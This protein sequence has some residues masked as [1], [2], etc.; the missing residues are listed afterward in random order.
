MRQFLFILVVLLCIAAAAFG[1]S[2]AGAGAIEGVVQDEAQAVIPQ[3]NV[4][5]RNAQTGQVRQLQT[6]GTGRY[7][8]AGLQPG[9]YEIEVQSAGF[10]RVIHKGITVLVGQKAM[11]DVMLKVAATQETVTVTGELP[12]V[13]TD[14]TEVSSYVTEREVQNL[15]VNG[16]RWDNFV[17]LTPAV[18][19]DGNYGMVS[20]RGISGLYNNNMIDGADNNQ[21][22]FSEARGRTRIGYSISQSTIKEFQVGQSNYSAEFGRAAGGLVNA[23]TRSGTNAAHGE[24]FYYIRD[25]AMNAQNPTIAASGQQK[26]DDRRQQFGGFLGGA[27]KKDKLFYLL[28]YD[29]QKRNFPAAILP[30]STSFYN[31][32]SSKVAPGFDNLA[33]LYKGLETLQPRSGNQNLGLAKLDWQMSSANLLSTTLNVLRWDSLNGIQTQPKHGY[34]ATA[35]G[36]DNVAHEFV[37]T[38]LSS[39]LTPTTLNEFRFQYGRDFESQNPNAPGPY[40][41]P[42]NGINTGMPAYLPRAAYPNEKTL[43]FVNNLSLVRGSHQLKIGAEMRYVRDSYIN[44]Y[45]GG[46]V[47]NYSS[48]NDLALDCPNATGFPLTGCTPT[49]TGT[50]TQFTGV[51]GKHYSSFYQAFDALNQ[52]GA[53][54]FNTVDYALYL[55]DNLKLGRKLTVNLGL[56]YE[57]QAMPEVASPNPDLPLSAKFN[58]DRN[59]FGPRVG[60]AWTPVNKF[61]VRAGY[62]LYY[63][64]TQN[65][66][67]SQA[68]MSNGARTQT[69][70][71]ASNYAGSPS[72]P[73]TFSAIPTGTASK[74]DASLL[75]ADYVNP[76]IH[77]FEFSLEREVGRGIAVQATYMASRGLRLPYFRDTNLFPTSSTITYTVDCSAAGSSPACAD[78]PSSFTVP[79]YT[80]GAN[81]PNANY[82]R[83]T[84][85]ESIV[86]SWY[87]GLVLEARKRQGRSLSFN[88]SLTYAKAIDTGQSGSSAT[89]FSGIYPLDPYNLSS[90]KAVSVLDQRKRFVSS[91]VWSPLFFENSDPAVRAILHGWQLSSILTLADGRPIDATVSGSPTS[92]LTPG[93][94]GGIGSG[95]LGVSGDTRAPWLSRGAYL[96]AGL[97][98]VDFRLQRTFRLTERA[99]LEFMGEAFNLFN[100]T[101]ITAQTNTAFGISGT[102]LIGRSYFLETSSTGNT[103][104]RERQLQFG[105]RLRF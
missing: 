28:S 14:K 11:V 3:A 36:S 89:F 68:L 17:L 102:T 51:A 20:Y 74:P 91:V 38:R 96:T 48:L 47:Y 104:Y 32:P 105:F 70:F 35:N 77:Q 41:S 61:V 37:I 69:Y 63:G 21:A 98:N 22:F 76:A 45:Q 82:G 4:T 43:Q 9:E 93:K 83:L 62:G 94:S 92:S 87:H 73:S 31:K 18:T 19:T 100:R 90:E 7:L 84:V 65:S 27:I 103:F 81:R 54:Q 57:L 60:F 25:A 23:V 5:V 80:K 6:D 75:A 1:Q 30:Y 88:M 29:Q 64:R 49:P 46:G 16:R 52:G 39:T 59:N 55:Q 15:P 8:A 34:D 42:S 72:F 86:R 66:T 13:E 56:R 95:L 24:F 99:R 44:L 12:A 71:F 50:G 85:A 58:T 10:A 78:A 67:L 26:P 33:G 40:V 79:Y 53:A 97:A 101:N 2:G